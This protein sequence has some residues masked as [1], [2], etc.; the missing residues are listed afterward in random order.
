MPIAASAASTSLTACTPR[1]TFRLSSSSSSPSRRKLS[2]LRRP[3]RSSLEIRRDQEPAC[4]RP[5]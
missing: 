4:R 5:P 3:K 2:S 1:R